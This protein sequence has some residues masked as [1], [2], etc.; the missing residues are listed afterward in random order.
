[1]HSHRDSGN[2]QT[3]NILGILPQLRLIVN[4]LC[5]LRV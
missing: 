3:G 4:K 2:E 5:N 1:M